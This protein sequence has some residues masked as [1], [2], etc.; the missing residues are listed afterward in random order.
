[1]RIVIQ[2][3]ASKRSDAGRLKD[4]TGTPVTFVAHPEN[5]VGAQ[6]R[7]CRP[8]DLAD[9]GLGTWRDVLVKYNQGFVRT[10]S[11]PDRLLPAGN[12]YE[13]PIYE[14]LVRRF[15]PT[16]VYVLSAG[17]GLVRADC[18]LPDYNITFSK[19]ADVPR[20]FRRNESEPGWSDF[21]QLRDSDRDDDETHFFGTP[22]YLETFY[23]LTAGLR[24]NFLIHHRAKLR[25]RDGYEYVPFVGTAR[26]NW[27]YLAA[28]AFLD[29]R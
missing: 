8:D 9:S 10:G 16:N 4:R 29:N 25:S 3:A 27:H 12:L 11:N 7:Y 2:C 13:P 20:E 6:G 1:M 28:V 19:S 14:K 22:T 26:T 15:H 18:L 23:R 24:G 5:V 21:N 17:W